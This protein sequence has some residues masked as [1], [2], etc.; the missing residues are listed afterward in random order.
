MLIDVEYSDDGWL[1]DI[2]FKV[3]KFIN[4]PSMNQ[5]Y[6]YNNSIIDGIQCDSTSLQ[7]CRSAVNG[8]SSFV[9]T[10]F[11]FLCVDHVPCPCC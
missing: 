4:P 3:L 1:N 2:I 11:H 10:L 8:P 6:S 9:V 5:H 7:T